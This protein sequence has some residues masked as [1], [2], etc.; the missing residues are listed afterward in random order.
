MSLLT[1]IAQ[2]QL[3]AFIIG[4]PASDVLL[5]I[6]DITVPFSEEEILEHT[7]L[8]RKW[9]VFIRDPRNPWATRGS[10][11]CAVCGR[12]FNGRGNQCGDCILLMKCSR[13]LMFRPVKS[14]AAPEYCSRA[15]KL[16]RRKLSESF[17]A[18]KKLNRHIESLTIYQGRCSKHKTAWMANHIGC[19]ECYMWRATSSVRTYKFHYTHIEKLTGNQVMTIDIERKLVTEYHE[20]FMFGQ[21]KSAEL[22]K[23]ALAMPDAPGVWSIWLGRHLLDVA[24]TVNVRREALLFVRRIIQPDNMKYL[25]LRHRAGFGSLKF[26]VVKVPVENKLRRHSIESKYAQKHKS[27]MTVWHPAPGQKI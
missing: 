24:E 20:A 9:A 19:M 18:R 7:A 23:K 1:P 6:D 21:I 3:T 12:R 4:W 13:C 16:N 15:C 25:G 10:T 14:K 11:P 26:K 27:E 2:I 17:S 8:G 22:Y 5:E